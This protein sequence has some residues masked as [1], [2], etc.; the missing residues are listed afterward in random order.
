MRYIMKDLTKGNI[1]TTF[2]KFSIPI[3]L[4]SVLSSMF[5]IINTSIAG[6]YLGD[7]GLAAT[8]ATVYFIAFVES[9]YYG[10]AYGISVYVAK[11]FAAKRYRDL[12]E[13]LYSNLIFVAVTVTALAAICIPLYR[14]IFHFLKVDAV[15]W[16]DAR[17]YFSLLL[18][19]MVIARCSLCM[20]FA[21]N[22][23]GVT[24]FP[25]YMSTLSAVLTIA[26]NLVSVVLLDM[27][28]LG[29]GLSNIIASLVALILYL[30]RFRLYFRELGIGKERFQFRM[31]AVKHLF[32]YSLPNIFQQMATYVCSMFLSPLRN[33]LGYTV[34]ASMSIIG[35]IN[36]L[37]TT[38]YY[39]A[40]R[41]S[42]NYISQCLGAQKY[43]QIS[44]AVGVAFYQGMLFCLIVMASVYFFPEQIAG[45]F[46]NDNSDPVVMQNVIHYIRYFLPFLFFQVV[47][48]VFHSVFR[49]AKAGVHL[50]V[51]SLMSAVI[52]LIATFFLAPRM[53]IVGLHV[54]AVISWICECIYIAIVY[55]SGRWLS[56][57]LRA[58]MKKADTV[59]AAEHPIKA[60]AE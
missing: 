42:G 59:S 35:S 24:T 49:G 13:C 1:H 8:G 44:K 53:G 11:L 23:M 43:K 29:L 46:I 36:N 45:F 38:V 34:I 33:A 51:S 2:L 30:I 39:A 19:N 40:A 9:F 25:L 28:V 4:S 37:H 56:K 10:V 22:A 7:K 50:I 32:S 60:L 17:T 26:G 20:L 57:E 31:H 18:V 54:S 16:E 6:L 52:N 14:P 27:G 5:G 58:E 21:C 47:C 41:T 12:R 15:I 55:F 48:G 3:I